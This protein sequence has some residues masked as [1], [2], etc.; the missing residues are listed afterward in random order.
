MWYIVKISILDSILD[1]YSFV[2]RNKILF[3]KDTYLKKIAL[4][5]KHKTGN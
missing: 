3:K 4:R 5:N 2:C 1:F